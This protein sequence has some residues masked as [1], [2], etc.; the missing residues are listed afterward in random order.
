LEK[1]QR[2][3]F[4]ILRLADRERKEDLEPPCWERIKV[5]KGAEEK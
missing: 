2:Q 1:T 4:R 3:D 5:M